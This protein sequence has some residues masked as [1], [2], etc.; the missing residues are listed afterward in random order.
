M[1]Y[2]EIIEDPLFTE[3]QFSKEWIEA[4]IINI[5]V[6]AS[7]KKEYIKG[8]DHRAEHH[9][10]KA[11]RLFLQA[12]DSIPEEKF[13]ILYYIGKNDSDYSMGRAILFDILKRS[14]CPLEL[15]DKTL[16]DNDVTLARHA[17]KCKSKRLKH[18]Q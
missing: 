7:I 4:E 2:D 1:N 10:W 14:D 16:N 9:R 3:L 13:N 11:F 8:E 6:F 17:L 15:I 12:N 5:E 18:L